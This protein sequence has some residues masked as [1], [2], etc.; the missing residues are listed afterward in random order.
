MLWLLWVAAVGALACLPDGSVQLER[1]PASKPRL[2]LDAAACTTC[3]QAHCP[4]APFRPQCNTHPPY[5][6]PAVVRALHPR[7]L[8]SQLHHSTH[9]LQARRGRALTPSHLPTAPARPARCPSWRTSATVGGWGWLRVC[10]ELWVCWELTTQERPQLPSALLAALPALLNHPSCLP[11]P[12]SHLPQPCPTCP[13]VGTAG[14]RPCARMLTWQPTSPPSALTR[15]TRTPARR[16]R[17]C[18]AASPQRGRLRLHRRTTRR[19][20]AAWLV[21]WLATWLPPRRSLLAPPLQLSAS[22][23]RRRLRSCLAPC[24]QR[25]WC[26]RVRATAHA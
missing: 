22:W 14:S 23:R 25:C 10:C 7:H 4:H 16:P 1:C 13:S 20:W 21:P 2:L 5:R 26:E 6:C 17:R 3:L 12:P 11:T 24:W 18:R 15:P 9:H 19:A 8:P